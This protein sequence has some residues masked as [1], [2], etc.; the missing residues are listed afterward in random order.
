MKTRAFSLREA[1][2]SIW[3]CLAVLALCLQAAGAPPRLEVFHKARALQ[4]GEVIFFDVRSG[5]PL[6]QLEAR[7]FGRIFPLYEDG[8]PGLWRGLVGIDLETGPGRHMVLLDGTDAEGNAVRADY[9]LTVR[10]KVFPVRRISV[11]EKYVTPPPEVQ[12]RIRRE[13]EKVGRIYGTTR[14]ER[15][16]KG[17]WV[18]P[19]PGPVISEF[20]KRSII[21]GQPR[22]PHAGTDFRGETGAPVRAVNRGRVVL[23]EDLY[24]SGN[25]IILDHG[26][27]LYT[28]YAHLSRRQAKEGE[29]VAAG[30]I[31]GRVGATGRVTGPH[32]HLSVRLVQARVDPI[33]LLAVMR[34]SREAGSSRK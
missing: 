14:P 6:A 29:E 4:P 12:E 7:A 23:A 19:V 33:S 34:P 8:S 28:Y 13:S 16:W 21:N 32:L 31:I 20:G 11:D 5:A 25:T 26:H 2:K 17:A 30:D 18:M 27:G 9:E 10:R 3:P 22:S 24:F 15:L 1:A